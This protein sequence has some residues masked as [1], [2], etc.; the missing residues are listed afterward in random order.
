MEPELAD[1]FIGLRHDLLAPDEAF[2][3]ELAVFVT[4][5]FLDSL[6]RGLAEVGGG[7]ERLEKIGKRLAVGIVK[8]LKE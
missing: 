5:G 1:D 3:L 8:R 6:D 2:Q 4:E 7:G